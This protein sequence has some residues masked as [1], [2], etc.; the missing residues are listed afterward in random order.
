M[1]VFID[2]MV[3][4]SAT[5]PEVDG[6]KLVLQRLQNSKLK[7]PFTPRDL[8]RKGWAGLETAGSVQAAISVLVD[9]GHLVS[10]EEQTGGRPSISYEWVKS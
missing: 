4:V 2:V 1:P 9:H 3:E 8:Q 10:H 5:S 7:A 6:A